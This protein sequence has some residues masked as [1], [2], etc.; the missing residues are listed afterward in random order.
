MDTNCFDAFMCYIFVLL[1]AVL[2]K[3][4]GV[5][6]GDESPTHASE[7]QPK[8]Q[9]LMIGLITLSARNFSENKIYKSSEVHLSFG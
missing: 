3:E 4:K 9:G 7:T 2:A 8:D 1:Q 5:A 6:L